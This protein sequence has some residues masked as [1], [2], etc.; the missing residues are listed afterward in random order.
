MLRQTL[1]KTSSKLKLKV[2]DP[3]E[4][5]VKLENEFHNE[6]VIEKN[7]DEG[8]ILLSTINQEEFK[9]LLSQII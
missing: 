9:N 1:K 6:S 2:K 3:F 4:K 5:R 8:S 7:E